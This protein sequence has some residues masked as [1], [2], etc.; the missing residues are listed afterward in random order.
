MIH[1]QKSLYSDQGYL[2]FT[3]PVKSFSNLTSKVLVSSFWNLL[4]SV[5]SMGSIFIVIDALSKSLGEEGISLIEMILT[6]FD[7]NLNV[8]ALVFMYMVWCGF[9][10]TGTLYACHVVKR[11]FRAGA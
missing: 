5:S 1:F 2:T 10:R 3:L 4:A 7:E 11:I 6:L 8:G 9:Y